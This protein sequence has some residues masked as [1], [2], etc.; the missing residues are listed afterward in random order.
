MKYEG[1]QLL[2][3]LPINESSQ[4]NETKYIILT[5]SFYYNFS[6]EENLT[7]QHQFLVLVGTYVV[8]SSPNLHDLNKLSR[9]KDLLA[10]PPTNLKTKER[11]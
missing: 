2:P 9:N 5:S 1:S 6:K 4:P 11:H 10:P 7:C 3:E 8:Y